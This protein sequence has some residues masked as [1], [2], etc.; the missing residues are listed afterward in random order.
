MYSM[1]SVLPGQV[2]N[3]IK[4]YEMIRDNDYIAVGVSGGKDSLALLCVLAELRGYLPAKFDIRAFRVSLGLDNDCD[5]SYISG[6]CTKL[7]VGYEIIETQIGKIVFEERKETSP[8][9]LCSK[10]RR[11][12]LN[13]AAKAA[14][15][16]KVALGHSKDDL[17]ETYLLSLF[18]EGRLSTF[19]PV[20]WLSETGLY[21]IRPLCYSY[22]KDV[23]YFVN[24][25][26]L[27]PVKSPC[28]WDKESK[29]HEIRDLVRSLSHDNPHLR[30]NI[31]GTIQRNH[32]SGW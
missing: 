17:I 29:R 28:P 25:K 26:G 6:L 24:Q 4:D 31:F 9:S 23:R 21:V 11:G 27:T 32:I 20:T 3:I 14:G 12:A 15:C 8:C 18:Y 5:M 13:D 10:M 16:N 22:E 30:A 7:G 2:R 19:S 1:G